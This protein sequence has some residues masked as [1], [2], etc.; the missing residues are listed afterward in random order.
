[1]NSC[2]SFIPCPSGGKSK[3]FACWWC[4]SGKTAREAVSEQRAHLHQSIVGSGFKSAQMY[5]QRHAIF[6][7]QTSHLQSHYDVFPE[8]SFVNGIDPRLYPSHVVQ[9]TSP[10]RQVQL[11]SGWGECLVKRKKRIV[12]SGV[13]GKLS[14]WLRDTQLVKMFGGFSLNLAGTRVTS[15]GD[16]KAKGGGGYLM[17]DIIWQLSCVCVCH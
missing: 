5:K 4:S 1:M 16:P 13:S 6:M 12:N 7:A 8:E 10:H 2:L 15:Q 17:N 9:R 11:P 3:Y 14:W